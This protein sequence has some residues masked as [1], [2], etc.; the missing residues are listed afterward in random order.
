MSPVIQEIRRRCPLAVGARFSCANGSDLSLPIPYVHAL[1]DTYVIP[2]G[3]RNDE[4]LLR[5]S[6]EAGFVVPSG[7]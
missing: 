1:V 6:L 3:Y 4:T 5:P 7:N 2:S